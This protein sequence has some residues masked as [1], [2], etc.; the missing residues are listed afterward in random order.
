MAEEATQA[1]GEKNKGLATG[2]IAGL[3][4]II[5]A[6]V[7]VL[8][9]VFGGKGSG[10]LNDDYFKTDDT[11]Y[12]LSMDGNEIAMDD[13]TLNLKKF[14]I[15]YTRDGEKIT[16]QKTYYEFA[17]NETAEKAK[18]SIDL[19][20]DEN[21]AE[22]YVDGNYLVIVAKE[23]VYAEL[24]TGDVEQQIEFMKM[25]Q[26]MSAEMEEVEVVEEAAENIEDEVE[27]VEEN[28]VEGE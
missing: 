23:N 6:V 25:T 13:T 11:K 14:H 24:S 1:K 18:N 21:V 2:I 27:I 7:V 22:V 17:N 12:V 19:S 9:V 8:V 20:D 10:G 16:S 15:V 26:E 28:A 5:V 4:V 3:A